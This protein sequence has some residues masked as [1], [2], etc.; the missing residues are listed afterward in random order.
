MPKSIWKGE[1]SFGLV[2]IPVSLYSIEEQDELKFHLLDKKTKS[3]VHYQRIS[4]K[5][6]KEVPWDQVVKGFEFEKDRYIIVDEKKFEKASQ[7]L[8][9]AINIE[10]FVDFQEIDSLYLIKPYYL[11]PESKNKKAY[12]LL[13]ESLK[14]TNKAGVAKVIIRT[15][16]SICLIL[17]HHH[18]LLLYLIHFKDEIR[19]EKEMDV[20]KEDFKNYK[21]SQSEIKMAVTLIDEMTTKWQP[22]KYHNEYRDALK[23]WL[24]QQIAKQPVIKEEEDTEVVNENSADVVDFISLLKESMQKRTSAE[25]SNKKKSS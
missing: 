19:E 4:E 11:I 20:P 5:T 16:E 7:D 18:A 10:E 23:K 14:K 25:K 2:S 1:I 21:V 13:R 9:K 22:E 3:R 17:P 15:K 8:F 6:G 12:V 24:D